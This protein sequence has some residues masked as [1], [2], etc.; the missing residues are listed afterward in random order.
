MEGKNKMYA[1]F[2]CDVVTNVSRIS[3]AK[4]SLFVNMIESRSKDRKRMNT[5]RQLL[6]FGLMFT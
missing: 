2:M 6:N 4:H 3:I 5:N 1:G